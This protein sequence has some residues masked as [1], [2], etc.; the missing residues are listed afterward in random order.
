MK[1]LYYEKAHGTWTVG[2]YTPLGKWIEES[3]HCF[4]ILAAQRVA[5]LN[6]T[7]VPLFSEDNLTLE[8]LINYID[9]FLSRPDSISAQVMLTRLKNVLR[10][11]SQHLNFVDQITYKKFMETRGAGEKSWNLYTQTVDKAYKVRREIIE[12]QEIKTE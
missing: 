4:K 1:Y 6:G 10:K 8:E 5:W 3:N 12:S 2:F 11:I 7:K 9:D